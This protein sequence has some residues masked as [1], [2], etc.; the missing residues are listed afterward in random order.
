MSYKTAYS[1]KGWTLVNTGSNYYSA[2]K[3]NVRVAVGSIR[4]G[5]KA[6]LTRR[7]RQKV[8]MMEARGGR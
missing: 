7:F 1:Y 6:D 5:D 4:H 3:G 2:C 8:D